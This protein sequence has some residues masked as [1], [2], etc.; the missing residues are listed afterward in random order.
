MNRF[1]RR[2]A[3]NVS[4]LLLACAAVW[5]WNTAHGMTLQHPSLVTGWLLS[6]LMLFLTAYNWRKKLP[7]SSLS[8]RA[9]G[10]L[11][12]LPLLVL[13]GMLVG[14]RLAGVSVP[15]AA[16]LAAYPPLLLGILLVLPIKSSRWLQLHIYGG[17]FAV[18]VFALHV[19]VR[20]PSGALETAL[21]AL[22]VLVA[23]S[24]VVGLY[25]T[26]RFP[27]LISN[28][29][30]ELLFERIPAFVTRRRHE[31]EELVL[32]TARETNGTALPDF[33]ASRLHDYFSGP[34]NLWAHLRE[35]RRPLQ[36]LQAELKS[37]ESYCSPEERQALVTLAGYVQSK[38]E[39][40]YDYAHQAALK[41]WL[42]LHLPLSYALLLLSGLHVL[43]VH[44]FGGIR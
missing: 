1:A 14:P 35:S 25:M 5:V 13:V 38:D 4:C 37:L 39:L 19:G 18:F 17:L 21:Y 43:V 11:T 29:G 6:G 20:W 24:G 27:A 28:R 26:R 33:Y 7:F 8:R 41:Y 16:A 40:D 15:T 44:A 12:M 9:S 3:F 36:T 2:R 22:F 32:A 31:A 30:E 42:F 34:R 23:G 10:V